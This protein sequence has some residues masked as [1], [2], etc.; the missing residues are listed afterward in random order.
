MNPQ[1]VKLDENIRDFC[2]LP[3][4]I[5]VLLCAMLRLNLTTLFTG[6]SK[7]DVRDA[8]TKAPLVRARLL[9][10]NAHVLSEASYQARLHSLVAEETGALQQTPAEKN[11]MEA[12]SDPA[13]MMGGMKNQILYISMQG[14]VAYWTSTFF[15]GFLVGKTPFPLT[16]RF[17]PMLQ[18]GIEVPS[19]DVSYVSG[20]SFYFLVFMASHGL[21]AL[22][23]S[24][25]QSSTPMDPRS[26]A[27]GISAG[28][29]PGPM[30]SFGQPNTKQLYQTELASF[31][32]FHPQSQVT[33]ALDQ[34]ESRWIGM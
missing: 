14:G 28:D 15:S 19:L 6:K 27:T 29:A 4:I 12:M 5:V 31:Q 16:F 26:S 11:A 21:T 34:L 7:L 1:Q 18:R 17:K 3:L 32:I 22:V 30:G 25:L 10:A 2:F 23:L 33:H 8:K 20:L 9:K 24:M 13:A